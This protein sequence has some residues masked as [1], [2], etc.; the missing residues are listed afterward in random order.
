MQLLTILFV[1]LKHTNVICWPWIWIASPLWI[2]VLIVIVGYYI[3]RWAN[4][5]KI[6]FSEYLSAIIK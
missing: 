3:V 1:V 4:D 5:G 6:T 2:T